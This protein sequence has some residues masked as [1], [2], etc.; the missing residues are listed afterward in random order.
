MHSVIIMLATTG[1][2]DPPALTPSICSYYLL[3]KDNAVA[4][5]ISRITIKL[6][7]SRIINEHKTGFVQVWKVRGKMA[8]WGLVR[9]NQGKSGNF[10]QSLEKLGF[11]GEVREKL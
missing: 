2:N 4:W 6:E 11:V 1:P 9:E 3:L 5:Q 8:I 7:L 10:F